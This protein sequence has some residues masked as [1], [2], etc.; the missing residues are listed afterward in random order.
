MRQEATRLV[1]S[2]L[3]FRNRLLQFAIQYKYCN[4][5][6]EVVQYF[7]SVLILLKNYFGGSI[8]N[9]K[10]IIVQLILKQNRKLT[11]GSAEKTSI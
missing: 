7:G 1:V 2:S 10:K 3:W 6:T 8:Q 11:L 5:W 9:W 4:R